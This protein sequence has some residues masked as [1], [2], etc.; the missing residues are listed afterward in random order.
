MTTLLDHS[1]RTRA[2]QFR[3]HVSRVQAA[4][5]PRLVV[6]EDDPDI[7]ALFGDIAADEYDLVAL[8]RETHVPAIDAQEPDVLLIGTVTS[9]SSSALTPQELAGLAARHMRLHRVPIVILTA[10]AE[11]LGDRRLAELSAATLVSLPFDIKTML[12]VLKSVSRHEGSPVRMT[13]PELCH[14]GFD[15]SGDDC[16]YCSPISSGART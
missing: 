16:A 9:D 11:L 2:R 12:C 14:H 4:T 6:L 3:R 7:V 10:D 1:D 5:R 15:V 13:L 8:P